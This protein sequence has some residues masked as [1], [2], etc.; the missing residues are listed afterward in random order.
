MSGTR[1]FSHNKRIKTVQKSQNKGGSLLQE[2]VISSN[3]TREF[4]YELSLT[5]L[6]PSFS[7]N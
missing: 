3:L 4:L 6:P 5:P 2:S 7:Q 1:I